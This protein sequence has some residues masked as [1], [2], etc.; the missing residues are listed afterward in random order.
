MNR[1]IAMDDWGVSEARSASIQAKQPQASIFDLVGVQ[2]GRMRSFQSF[3]QCV[4]FVS[5]QTNRTHYEVKRLLAQKRESIREG[6]YT[7]RL[8]SPFFQKRG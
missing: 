5:C 6:T 2:Q 8:T 3:M 4:S 1:I 7:L